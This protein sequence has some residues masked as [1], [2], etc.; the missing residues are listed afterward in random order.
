MGVL[1]DRR[2]WDRLKGI[3][4]EELVV[5]Y[6]SLVGGEPTELNRDDLIESW[7]EGLGGYE[8]T[9]HLI[10]NHLV[11][12]DGDTAVC[13]ATFQATHFLPTEY[14]SS[15]WTLG[16]D[17][18]WNLTR[19]NDRWEISEVIMTAKWADGNQQLQQLAAER[20]VE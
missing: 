2:E 18:E 9:Q 12:I 20:T 7:R 4:A 19:A 6:S 11:D 10:A 16:G 3:F 15:R 5:D 17:Y 1:A 14:G 13:T 8:A